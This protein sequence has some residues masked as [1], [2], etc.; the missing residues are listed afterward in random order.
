MGAE[1][2]HT[3]L[4][5]RARTFPRS[6]ATLLVVSVLA[7]AF[8]LH[9]I[10]AQ[11]ISP[12]FKDEG[13]TYRSPALPDYAVV[14]LLLAAVGL[15]MPRPITR[16]SHFM[17]W[18]LFVTVGAPS[19]LVAQYATTLDSTQALVLGLVTLA[20]FACLAVGVRLG[21]PSRLVVRNPV[22]VP[23]FW[24]AVAVVSILIYAYVFVAVGMRFSYLSFTDVY[25]VRDQYVRHLA[26]APGLAYLVP[27]Q[28]TVLNPLIMIRG[29]VRRR[30]SL[31]LIGIIAQALLYLATGEKSIF[32]SIL[33]V[34]AVYLATRKGRLHPATLIWSVIAAGAAAWLLDLATGSILWS[35]I[36][37]RRFLIV[38]GALTGAYVSVFSGH[39]KGHFSDVIGLIPSS[40]HG[41]AVALVGRRFTHEDDVSANASWLAHGYFSLGYA[42]IALETLVVLVL[43]LAAE[44]VTRRMPLSVACS[45]FVLPVIALA[46]SSPFTT[47][48]SH[49][50]LVALVVAL[51][52]PDAERDDSAHGERRTTWWP[53]ALRPRRRRVASEL[54]GRVPRT[55]P[56]P[57]PPRVASPARRD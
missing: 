54:T 11:H 3:S 20:V 24:A 51:T 13:L 4:R 21:P 47:I 12:E 52:L 14:L 31:L 44:A 19:A 27:T 53:D 46:S 7:Y 17:L 16:V 50:Y 22:R 28:F 45:L 40:F 33:I 32:F 26:T 15:L 18:V 10:Y 56:R 35:S 30:P 36:A 43:L 42:G 5:A 9:L 48:L 23:Y 2:A 57:G 6:P 49:G 39:A 55:P 34:P 25:Q 29:L 38:P 37:V 41:S 8:A 1:L